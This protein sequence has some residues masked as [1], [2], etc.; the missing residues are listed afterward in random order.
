M[1]SAR[2]L[3]AVQ[4]ALVLVATVGGAST[5]AF[6][7]EPSAPPPVDE[8]AV[9]LQDLER[10]SQQM[11][12]QV[13]EQQAAVEAERERL[14]S[15]EAAAAAAL[16]DYQLAQRTADLAAAESLAQ[17]R[18]L[19]AATRRTEAA[20]CGWSSTSAPCTARAWATSGCRSTTRC[21]ARAARR[22]SSTGCRWPSGWAPRAAARW[23]SWPTCRPSSSWR[24][25][26]R[27]RRAGVA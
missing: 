5:A 23:A 24:R 16:Q 4:L 25:T 8:S 21:W 10:Q 11:A 19:A 13:R 27:C 7:A 6:A 26:G 12:A 14:A 15:A 17:A 3:C 18:R 1:L 9:S 20:G 2:R 22:P